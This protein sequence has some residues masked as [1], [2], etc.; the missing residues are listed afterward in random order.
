MCLSE[1]ANKFFTCEPRLN[2]RFLFCNPEMGDNN[3]STND[4]DM[5]IIAVFYLMC[6]VLAV[7]ILLYATALYSISKIRIPNASYPVSLKIAGTLGGLYAAFNVIWFLW[8]QGGLLPEFTL[9]MFFA[10]GS[11]YVFHML[12]KRYYSTGL[13]KNVGV[14]VM[15]YIL[16]GV[17]VGVIRFLLGSGD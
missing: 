12:M 3:I 1:I 15:V 16:T 11:F 17:I 5:G 4:Q 2:P 10:T 6:V 8:P 7:S 9:K 14:Y 13:V